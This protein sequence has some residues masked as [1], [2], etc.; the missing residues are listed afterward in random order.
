MHFFLRAETKIHENL[1]CNIFYKQKYSK[2][3]NNKPP[4][5]SDLNAIQLREILMNVNFPNG[6]S[7]IIRI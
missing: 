1:L 2:N 5:F 6:N 3:E 4:R 7:Y